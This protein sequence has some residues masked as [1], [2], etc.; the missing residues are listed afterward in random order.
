VT[1]VALDYERV[2][3]AEIAGEDLGAVIEDGEHHSLT[4]NTGHHP[5]AKAFCLVALDRRNDPLIAVSRWRAA[6]APGLPA[7]PTG[8]FWGVDRL[9]REA[10]PASL[11]LARSLLSPARS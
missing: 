7:H 5:F 10:T 1:A 6:R 3:L 11:G 8:W 4:L 9:Q 2:H